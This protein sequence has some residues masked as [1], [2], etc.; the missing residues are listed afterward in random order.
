[1]SRPPARR[2]FRPARA[3]LAWTLLGL[4]LLSGATTEDAIMLDARRKKIEN[5]SQ[6]NLN[7]LKRNYETYLKLPPERRAQLSHL[8]DELV[9]DAKNGG[10]LRKLL[11]QYNAWLFKLSPFDRDKL[12]NTTDPG[13]RAELVQKLLQEQKQ[14]VARAARAPLLALLSTRLDSAPL[15]STKD[16]DV[17]LAAVEQNYLKEDSKERFASSMPPRVRHVEVVRAVIKQLRE[18]REAKTKMRPRET[19]LVETILD[20]IPNEAAKNQITRSGMPAQTRRQ[21]GQALGRSLLAEWKPELD[22]AVVSPAQIEE[23]SNK[24]IAG[25]TP[26]R[27]ENVQ[28]RLQSLNG[29]KFVAVV[30]ALQNSPKL[31]KARQPIMWL[32]RSFPSPA[33]DRGNRGAGQSG[34]AGKSAAKAANHPAEDA[35]N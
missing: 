24:W 1:M 23:L 4:V 10:H 15:L 11:D 9:Q 2:N 12:L 29:K 17:V 16:L 28:Q 26:E 25:V 5:L 13:E 32:L 20:A 33:G 8:D 27:L 34:S 21:L 22:E 31:K 19:A 18:E 3:P 14:R 7:Q 35:E 6:P 30:I